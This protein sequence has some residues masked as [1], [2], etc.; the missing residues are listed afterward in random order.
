MKIS[1]HSWK[2][3]VTSFT[4][5]TFFGWLQVGVYSKCKEI[6]QMLKNKSLNDNAKRVP[7]AEK[8]V[9]I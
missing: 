9:H 2:P 6:T 4:S 1:T 7:G 8:I 5:S 3:V